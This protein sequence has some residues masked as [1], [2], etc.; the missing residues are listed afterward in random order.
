LGLRIAAKDEGRCNATAGTS[1]GNEGL[2]ILRALLREVPSWTWLAAP[3]V[4]ALVVVVVVAIPSGSEDDGQVAEKSGADSS[5]V[6]SIDGG[7]EE[8][9][10]GRPAPED[11]SAKGTVEF[12]L[13]ALRQSNFI[14]LTG[15]VP[16]KWEADLEGLVHS[17]A[18]AVDHQVFTRAVAVTDLLVASTMNNRRE[19]LGIIGSGN[20]SFDSAAFEQ[21]LDTVV[22]LWKALRTMGL[23]ELD[24]LRQF[25]LASFGE[26]QLPKLVDFLD[27]LAR[28][29]SGQ[30]LEAELRS[31]DSASVEQE[32]VT[33]DEKWGDVVGIALTVKGERK[34]FKMVLVD[35]RWVPL[36]LASGWDEGIRGA[37]AGL[38]R[39]KQSLS[40][41]KPELLAG[42]EQIELMVKQIDAPGTVES[43]EQISTLLSI[44]S[45][46]P[47]SKEASAQGKMMGF[48]CVGC[49][50]YCADQAWFELCIPENYS[51]SDGQ[52]FAEVRCMQN[53]VAKGCSMDAAEC[54]CTGTRS[55]KHARRDRRS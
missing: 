45:L 55:S 51:D 39:M 54:H 2:S 50:H 26:K 20:P 4:W 22:G 47:F 35:G 52:S 9:P 46:L 41:A 16:R 30:G 18:D 48:A 33:H 49:C 21:S 1:N 14:G 8:Q 24:K 53:L 7:R 28:L 6:P 11:L 40:A 19:W 5:R 25:R 17:F 13:E 3:L 31:L 42:I 43:P 12:A 23:L 27:G 36:D 32:A 38:E 44:A 34:V 10:T 29:Q 37:Q 15:L